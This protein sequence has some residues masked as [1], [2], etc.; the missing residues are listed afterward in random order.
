MND[1]KAPR[2]AE[3]APRIAGWRRG[4]QP[5]LAALVALNLLAGAASRAQDLVGC[6]LVGA[7]LQCLPGVTES[8]QQQILQLQKDVA[9]DIQLEGAVQQSIDGL[10]GLALAGDASVG[11]LLTTT[12]A[13]D[14]QA[15][16]PTAGYHWYRLKP[17]QRS[18]VLIEGANG[19][20]YVPAPVDV[21]QSVMVVAV[22]NQ[23]GV[24]K[25]VASQ[26]IGPIQP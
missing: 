23:N 17:G 2:I 11:A 3:I 8:P 6:Q 26:P 15:A 16:L 14:A 22:V 20:T 18:W 10:R 13:A 1:R 5:A 19:T 9:A 24:V 7:S 25:R 12:V 21:G 4:P